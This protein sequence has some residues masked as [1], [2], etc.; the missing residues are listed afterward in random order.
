MIIKVLN[1]II[2]SIIIITFVVFFQGESKTWQNA[3]QYLNHPTPRATNKCIQV[4]SFTWNRTGD[5][6]DEKRA[7][8]VSA[9]T[10]NSWACWLPAC[11]LGQVDG[12]AW[13]GNRLNMYV[14]ITRPIVIII[15]NI[16]ILTIIIIL[17]IIMITAVPGHLGW[18]VAFRRRMPDGNCGNQLNGKIIQV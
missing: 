3:Q 9:R 16:I 5:D 11:L 12:M 2:T 7:C 8:C 18:L 10:T 1:I 15:I 17:R 6:D 14:Y 13:Q 4:L